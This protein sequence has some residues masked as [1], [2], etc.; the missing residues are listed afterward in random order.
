MQL[1]GFGSSDPLGQIELAL[2]YLADCCDGSV[3]ENGV[4]FNK[5][6]SELGKQLAEQVEVGL[7]IG[8]YLAA[9]KL[10]RRYGKQLSNAG[11]MLPDLES[12]IDAL[13][14]IDDKVVPLP[15]KKQDPWIGSQWRRG[16]S[17]QQQQA[18]DL[19]HE[20]FF[21]KPDKPFVLTGYAGTGK[22]FCVQR[23]VHSIRDLRQLR[24]ALVSPTHKATAV[25]AQFAES[26]GLEDVHIGTL[27]SLLHVMPGHAD[28]NGKTRL[29]INGFSQEPHYKEFGLVVIDE[30]SMIGEELLSFI[31]PTI[32]T[33]FMGDKAQLS[34]VEDEVDGEGRDSPIFDLP[35]G[36]NLTQVMRYDGAIAAYA[37]A[38][39]QDIA[40][41]FA[42]RVASGGNLTKIRDKEEWEMAV[43]EAFSRVEDLKQYPDDV[44]VLAWTNRRVAE[45]NKL[46]R[47]TLFDPSQE[48]CVGERLMAKV[49]IIKT[50]VRESFGTSKEILMQT[51]A[52]CTITQVK[53]GM[54]R[55]YFDEGWHPLLIKIAENNDITFFETYELSVITD[56]GSPLKLLLVSS[57]SLPKF[58]KFVQDY[59]KEILKCE[60]KPERKRMWRNYYK[61]M[62]EL[63]LVVKGGMVLQRLQYAFALTVHQSQGSTFKHVFVDQG[64][65]FGC[66]HPKTRNQLLYVSATRASKH[67]T[68]Y[69]KI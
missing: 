34:P 9:H 22:S 57:L 32:P 44:R 48:F 2:V 1:V 50:V 23:I 19:A 61:F 49:P 4:G 18:F 3:S 54:G 42:P 28:E 12:L 66:R 5:L 58:S 60:D 55:F 41:Q 16:L 43:I 47:N 33:I 10:L 64:N 39:R 13:S 7:A 26:A 31:P 11:L 21:N 67:L 63:N 62:E 65:I 27:H 6:D 53:S 46:I 68:I 35:C 59:K 24:V 29:E 69:S 15:L 52:E 30:S 14:G 20:W 45:L 38:I 17:E 36:I 51:C 8:Q 25:L 37:T 56:L 40:A